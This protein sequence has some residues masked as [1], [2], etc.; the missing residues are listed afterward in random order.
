METNKRMS[1][2]EYFLR[3]A[4]LAAKRGTCIRRQVGCVLVNKKN[5]VLATGYNG[6]PRGF[7]H[8]IDSPCEGA[9]YESGKGLNKCL[10]THAEQNALLQCHNVEEIY[11]AYVTASPCIHCVKL[12]LNTSCK[13]IVFLEEYPDD[14]S[15][16][17]WTRDYKRSWRKYTPA[18]TFDD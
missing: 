2:D 16:R 17:L 8:C 15:K 13:H 18:R 3:M 5:H 10:S 4:T 9:K 1:V 11:T 7:P 14:D 12:L 6:T